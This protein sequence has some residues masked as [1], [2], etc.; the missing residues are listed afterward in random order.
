VAS[1]TMIRENCEDRDCSEPAASVPLLPITFPRV[2]SIGPVYSPCP[3]RPH[4]RC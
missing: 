4:L 3:S 1:L 2:P